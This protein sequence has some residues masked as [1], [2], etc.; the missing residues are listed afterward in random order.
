MTD[1][2]DSRRK[3]LVADADLSGV[4]SAVAPEFEGIDL[5]APDEDERVEDVVS[6]DVD[7]LITQKAPVE[8]A[9]LDELPG[10]ELLLKLGRNYNNVDADAVRAREITFASMPRKGP[11]CVAELALTFVLSLSKDLLVSHES[12]AEGAYRMR[13]LKPEI[14]AQWEMAYHWMKNTRV[15]EAR[16]ETLGIVGMG[17]IG[18]ELARR[19]GVLDMSNVYYKRT[20]LSPELERR[21]DAKYRELDALLRESDYVCL[22][23]PHTPATEKMIGERELE[24]MREDAY[25]VNVCRGGV[26]DEDALVTAL[27]EERIAGAGL[28]V[29]EYEPLPEDSLLCTMDNVIL[30]PHMGGGTGTTP[31]L[32]LREAVTEAGRI[33]SGARP[34]NDLTDPL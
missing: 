22:A 21:F 2:S 15:H 16:H 31:Q 27:E 1:D 25:L 4:V 13:G 3:V 23:V 14:T 32:E 24:L 17:E 18:C 19:T 20:P 9:L 5:V 28:D 8:E 11:N 29:F 30:T 7:G 34:S 10:L 33:L 26:V 12:V 6:G